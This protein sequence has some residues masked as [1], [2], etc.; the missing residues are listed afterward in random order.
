MRLKK[1]QVSGF[2][3]FVDST[4]IRLPSHLVGVVGPNGCGGGET[5]VLDDALGLMRGTGAADHG[6]MDGQGQALRKLLPDRLLGHTGGLPDQAVADLGESRNPL[7]VERDVAIGGV[8]H[9]KGDF[10]C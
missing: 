3:S 1:L 10:K 9:G 8:G 2:K 4:D 6:L 5:G 7:G